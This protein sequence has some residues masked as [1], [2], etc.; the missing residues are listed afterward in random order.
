MNEQINEWINEETWRH[1]SLGGGGGGD[2]ACGA[3][4][5]GGDGSGGSVLLAINVRILETR[6]TSTTLFPALDRARTRRQLCN[7][8]AHRDPANSPKVRG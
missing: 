7:S 6:S 1:S 2:G 4:A 3:A 8:K 5:G